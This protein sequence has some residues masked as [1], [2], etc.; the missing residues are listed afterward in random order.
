[1]RPLFP[2]L[3]RDTRRILY[4]CFFAFFMNGTMTTMMGSLLPDMKLAYHLS[5]SQSGLMLSGHSLGNLLACFLSGLVPLWLGRRRAIVTL[6]AALSLGFL[7]TLL[8][9]NPVWLITAF[10]L[11][12]VA[13]GSISNF[14]NAT[15]NRVTGGSPSASNLLHSFFAMGAISAPLLFLLA[16]GVGGW[17]AAV[18]LLVLL[19]L[20]VTLNFSR[21]QLEDDR[22]DPADQAQ[23]SLIFLHNGSF[24]ISGGMMFFY[25]CAEYAINGWLVTYLQNKPELLAQFAANGGMGIMA[26][27]QTMATL[28]WLII[29]VGRLA[30]AALARRLPQK[31]LMMV[32]SVGVAL[33][34]TL[35]LLS[36]S[37]PLVT[38][39]VAGLG[40]CMAGI[41]PMIY[42][43]ASYITNLYPMGTSTLLAIGSVGAMLM[44]ALVGFMAD[45]YGFA[46]GMRS[47]LL[48]VGALLAL[49]IWNYLRKPTPIASPVAAGAAQ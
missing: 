35:L 26:Y 19:G 36:A 15:V 8:Y 29:L 47:I 42:S 7:M 40:F 23:K 5:D 14:N 2:N 4:A 48:G 21:V 49:S 13:R 33:F 28:L 12:G 18:V 34:F 11:T 44:P 9:G 45:A 30:S 1:M 17:Q 3:S 38:V 6:S 32:S 22:P 25:L 43:D 20:T 10:V 46:W 37:L 39:A 27:S 24:W 31:L 41:C 16:R